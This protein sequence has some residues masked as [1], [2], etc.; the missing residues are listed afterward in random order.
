[1]QKKLTVTLLIAFFSLSWAQSASATSERLTAEQLAAAENDYSMWFNQLNEHLLN[2]N[3]A[4]EKA[5]G[6]AAIINGTIGESKNSTSDIDTDGLLN[7]QAI[8]LNEIINQNELSESTLDVLTTWCFRPV[9]KTN[10]DHDTLL[11]R[12]IEHFS[13]NLNVLLIP[14]SIAVENQ[15]QALIK[16]ILTRMSEAKRSDHSHFITQAFNQTID[17]YIAE[18]PIPDTYIQAFKD[19]KALLSGLSIEKQPQIDSLINAYFPTSIKMSYVFLNDTPNFGTLYKVC[20]STNAVYAQCL[21]VTQTLINNSNSMVAKG[22][23]YATLM[24]MH[25]SRGKTDL[26]K[27][28]QQKQQAYKAKV[29][30]LAKATRAGG[31]VDNFLDP[32]YQKINLQPIDELKR[33]Q[34]LADYAYKKYREK[35]PGLIDPKDC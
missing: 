20:Q 15:D 10:C 9:I 7:N 4:Y 5:M 6:L 16:Q 32:E 35:I 23:G 24:A 11:S 8:I 19:D 25:E 1:M 12:Q 14:L 2:S 28:V 33:Q 17:D 31:F 13:D 29:Q 22:V 3:D 34:Q 21:K 27:S 30:C 18:N 26:L